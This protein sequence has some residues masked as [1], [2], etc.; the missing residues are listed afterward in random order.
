[1]TEQTIELDCP[2]G[3]PRPGDLFPSVIHD[4]GL[5]EDDFTITSKLFGEWTWLL[6]NTDKSE[7]FER[8]RGTTIKA[9]VTSL[10]ESGLIRYGSW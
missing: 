4:T 10:Y 5:T 6:T 9:R 2:P 3:L 7:L 1:M 8:V